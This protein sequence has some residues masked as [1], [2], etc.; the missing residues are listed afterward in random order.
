MPVSI[1]YLERTS[2]HSTDELSVVTERS[3][4]ATDGYGT[5][6][7]HKNDGKAYTEKR[8]SLLSDVKTENHK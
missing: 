4:L 2:I 6:G 7:T 1:V 8:S 3:R 5:H